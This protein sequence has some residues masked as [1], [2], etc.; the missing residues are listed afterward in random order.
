MMNDIK[1]LDLCPEVA[2]RAPTVDEM[3]S[4]DEQHLVT[5]LRL[6]DADLFGAAWQ[7]VA[8]VVLQKDANREPDQALRCWESHLARAHWLMTRGYR[9]L[10]G[11]SIMQNWAPRSAL[12]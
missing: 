11:N 12:Q 8:W 4:Y 5:Y 9:R 1:E 2:D 7:D 6:L 10:V 3:T